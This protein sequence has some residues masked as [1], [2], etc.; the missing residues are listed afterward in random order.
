MTNEYVNQI[1]NYQDLVH[2][3]LDGLVS[4]NKIMQTNTDNIM[5]I[6]GDETLDIFKWF[7][8]D[9]SSARFLIDYTN[10]LVYYHDSLDIYIWGVDHYGSKWVDVKFDNWK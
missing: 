6:N 1:D 10:E 7:I 4:C 2:Y 9:S 3:G 5:L 8:I